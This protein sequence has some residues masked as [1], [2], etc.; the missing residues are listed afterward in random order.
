MPFCHLASF[1]QKWLRFGGPEGVWGGIGT[2]SAVID[3]RYNWLG[4]GGRGPANEIPSQART[5]RVSQSRL[6]GYNEWRLRI[7]VE[8]AADVAGEG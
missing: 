3:S 4:E 7:L 1:C 6:R 5:A 2:V 8:P